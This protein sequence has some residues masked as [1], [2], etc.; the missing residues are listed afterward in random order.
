MA[1]WFRVFV[2]AGCVSSGVTVVGLAAAGFETLGLVAVSLT[3]VRFMPHPL[4]HSDAD[5]T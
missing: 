5:E 4:H 3:V 1:G 2:A